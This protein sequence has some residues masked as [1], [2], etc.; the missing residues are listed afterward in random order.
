MPSR[1]RQPASPA[2]LPGVPKGLS[3]FLYLAIELPA[4]KPLTPPV[5][6]SDTPLNFP[7]TQSVA[8]PVQLPDTAMNFMLTWHGQADV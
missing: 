2:G 1:P 6:L 8:A 5:Q 3:T 7:F 4:H